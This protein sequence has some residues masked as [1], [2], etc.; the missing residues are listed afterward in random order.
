MFARA[1]I[2]QNVGLF[3]GPDPGILERE[4]VCVCG[5]GGG[6]GWGVEDWVRVLD[7]AGP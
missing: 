4:C 3:S 2:M 6:G 5:G 1:C 7:K